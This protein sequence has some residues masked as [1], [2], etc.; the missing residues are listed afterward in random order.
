MR[1]G[2]TPWIET[3]EKKRED[4]KYQEFSALFDKAYAAIDLSSGHLFPDKWLGPEIQQMGRELWAKYR[5]PMGDA[6]MPLTNFGKKQAFLAGKALRKLNFMPSRIVVSPFKRALMTLDE[7]RRGHPALADLQVT[8]D[9]N[10]REHSHGRCENYGDW[11]FFLAVE[12]EYGIYM[13]TTGSYYCVYPL[14]ENRPMVR[15]RARR[16]L[17]RAKTIYKGEDVFCILHN[18]VIVSIFAELFQWSKEGFDQFFREQEPINCGLTVFEK[19]PNSFYPDKMLTK[20][21]NER[22]VLLG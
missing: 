6:E 5:M 12:P 16:F 19:D 7:V 14:G 11:R 4:P 17:D 2:E 3:E 13:K 8:I 1:H 15:A 18:V 9:E 10:L 22:L 21:H 20:E